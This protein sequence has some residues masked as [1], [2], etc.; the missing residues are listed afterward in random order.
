MWGKARNQRD[1]FSLQLLASW[2][3]LKLFFDKLLAEAIAG[4]VAAL[5][6]AGD[7]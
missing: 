2:L 7:R 3:R 1:R 5:R 4:E 6:S